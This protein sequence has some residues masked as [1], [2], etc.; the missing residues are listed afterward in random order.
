MKTFSK[1][2]IASALALS[3]LGWTPS[4]CGQSVGAPIAVRDVSAKPVWLNAEVLHADANSMVVREVGNERDIRTFT[5]AP[6][7]QGQIQKVLDNGGYQHG[8][9]IKIRYLQ[10]SSVALSIGGK[11]SKPPLQSTPRTTLHPLT[12]R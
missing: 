7:A 10:G 8:D 2:A 4:A 6:K 12:T 9:R 3:A 11:P 5:Y 1:L